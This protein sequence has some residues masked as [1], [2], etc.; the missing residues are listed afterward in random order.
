MNRWCPRKRWVS[1]NVKHTYTDALRLDC[2]L[3]PVSDINCSDLLTQPAQLHLRPDVYPETHGPGVIRLLT[4]GTALGLHVNDETET[5]SAQEPGSTVWGTCSN[6][7]VMMLEKSPAGVW[8]LGV[9]HFNHSSLF[10]NWTQTTISRLGMSDNIGLI[11]AHLCN[12][13]S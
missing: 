10:V 7:S 13:G 3:T 1:L 12:N 2:V 9:A 8:Q 4:C 6:Y 11:S 5:S